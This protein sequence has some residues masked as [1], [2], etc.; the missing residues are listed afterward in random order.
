VGTA[1]V[2]G[3]PLAFRSRDSGSA[4]DLNAQL[5]A[6]ALLII[7]LG[8]GTT[9]HLIATAL[10]IARVCF[11]P[12]FQGNAL[13]LIVLSVTSAF[14]GGLRASYFE[15]AFE[16]SFVT[17]L[18]EV[19]TWLRV[20]FHTGLSSWLIHLY[21]AIGAGVA[22]VIAEIIVVITT[23]SWANRFLVMPIPWDSVAK[24]ALA[25]GAMVVAIQFVPERDPSL[26]L[27]LSA[28][29]GGF[30]YVA[31]LGLL[32]FSRLQALIRPART[33]VSLP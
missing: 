6:N 24:L 20:I 31:V 8:L 21:D 5:R 2:A 18:I 15:Q 23:I 9:T 28:R 16:I 32:Y 17:R 27:V 10:P 30:V 12:Q 4:Y 26:G 3:Q 13:A 29:L 25:A 11:R 7:A 22:A 1:A 33:T 19:L 14:V